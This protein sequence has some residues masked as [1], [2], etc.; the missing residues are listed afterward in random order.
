MVQCG[1]M[2]YNVVQCGTMWYNVVQCGTM[3]YNVVQCGAEI[4]V[5]YSCV[6]HIVTCD[7]YLSL[8]DV[9]MCAGLNSDVVF[10]IKVN[11]RQSIILTM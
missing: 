11:L 9:C 6:S 7:N 5:I 8:P 3:W 1:T 10:L 4:H 2:W